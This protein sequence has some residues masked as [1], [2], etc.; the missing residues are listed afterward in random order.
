[1]P[2][3]GLNPDTIPKDDPGRPDT[4]AK[5]ERKFNKATGKIMGD[6]P[7]SGYDNVYALADVIGKLDLKPENQSVQEM[8][9]MIREALEHQEFSGTY[10]VH[11]R[12]PQDH[13]GIVAFNA[14]LAKIE[15]DWF[16]PIKR[17]CYPN[18]D[19]EEMK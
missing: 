4:L 6:G 17:I 3:A 14:Y 5:V 19:V 16:V 8:R 12:T 7:M 9:D 13:R 10:V 18:M 11:K 1:M 2:A 15:G